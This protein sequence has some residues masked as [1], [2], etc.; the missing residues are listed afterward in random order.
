MHT[1][2]VITHFKAVIEHFIIKILI[3][4]EQCSRDSTHVKGPNSYNRNAEE[5]L[6]G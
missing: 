5:T 6:L 3:N 1:P 2:F 4:P